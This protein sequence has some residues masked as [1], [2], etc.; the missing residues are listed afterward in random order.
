MQLVTLLIVLGCLAPLQA[1]VEAVPFGKGDLDGAPEPEWVKEQ[2]AMANAQAKP[3]ESLI[4]F[5]FLSGV[6]ALDNFWTI[7]AVALA[8]SQPVVKV[9]AGLTDPRC[10]QW[11]VTTVPAVVLADVHGNQWGVLQGNALKPRPLEQMLKAG[12]TKLLEIREYLAKETERAV[13]MAGHDVRQSRGIAALRKLSQIAGLPEAVQAKAHLDAL[14]A[15]ASVELQT[16]ARQMKEDPVAARTPLTRFQR[17][18]AETELGVQARRALDGEPL[19]LPEPPGGGSEDSGSA[20][21]LGG[22]R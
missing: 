17:V 4:V 13:E 9:S 1:A 14:K 16:L 11:G 8:A 10:E 19:E 15:K 3:N 22:G 5:A 21:L 20:D 6:P 18:W 12:P 7:N 2:D